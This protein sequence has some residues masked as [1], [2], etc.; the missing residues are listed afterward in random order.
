ML[1]VVVRKEGSQEREREREKGRE[2]E[3]GV[4]NSC[5]C[6]H[7]NRAPRVETLEETCVKLN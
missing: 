4:N 3:R 2:G 6:S 7:V 1:W 5:L